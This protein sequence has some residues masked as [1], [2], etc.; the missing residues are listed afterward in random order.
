MSDYYEKKKK[1]DSDK[2][3]QNLDTTVLATYAKAPCFS[4][5]HGSLGRDDHD[6]IIDAWLSKVL[7]LCQ[8]VATHWLRSDSDV[9][10]EI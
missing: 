7:C 1:I 9:L 2:T 8:V 4:G 10:S 3:N 6:W 5:A